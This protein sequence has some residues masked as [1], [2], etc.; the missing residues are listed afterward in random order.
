[1]YIRIR[2]L[3]IAAIPFNSG[4]QAVQRR[5]FHTKTLPVRLPPQQA[6]FLI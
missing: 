5:D 1:M 2:M 6:T 4:G 3:D